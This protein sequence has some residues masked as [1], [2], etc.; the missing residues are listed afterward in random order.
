MENIQWSCTAF[1]DLS[2]AALYEI[3]KLRS[4]VFVVEQQCIF[5][6]MDDKD[7]NSYHVTGLVDNKLIAYSRLIP[8]GIAFAETSIGRV[9]TANSARKS[10]AGKL[11]MNY[12]ILKAKELFGNQDIRIG[13]QLYLKKFYSSFGFNTVSEIYLEDGIEHIEMTL[14]T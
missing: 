6:D 10:G 14:Y 9:V 13:A 1:A 7:V 11:L 5:L 3:L 8:P 4:E 2:V 12:S